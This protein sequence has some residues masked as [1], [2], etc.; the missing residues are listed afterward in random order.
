MAL[1]FGNR[2]QYLIDQSSNL[3]FRAKSIDNK[4]EE[5]N[6]KQYQVISFLSEPDQDKL[7]QDLNL[8]LDAVDPWS[9]GTSFGLQSLNDLPGSYDVDFDKYLQTNGLAISLQEWNWSSAESLA[10][11]QFY[12][13]EYNYINLPFPYRNILYF[14]A[15]HG[16][17]VLCLFTINIINVKLSSYALIKFSYQQIVIIWTLKSFILFMSCMVIF[18][19]RFLM[20]LNWIHCDIRH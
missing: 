20:I 18:Y 16:I 11:N 15:Y 14:L 5:I 3:N 2:F 6:G 10:R 13:E 9:L 8:G 1:L 17:P 4:C 19:S 12:C 7:A